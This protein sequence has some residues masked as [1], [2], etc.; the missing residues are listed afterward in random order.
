MGSK[1]G[2]R[3]LMQEAGVPVVPGETPV[4]QSNDGSLAAAAARVG[5]PLLLKPSAGGGG[6]GMKVVRG[7]GSGGSTPIAA[8]RREAQAP[9]ATGRCTSSG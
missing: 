8:A 2:A 9:S 7:R 1:I 3:R 6:I 5:F 4:D